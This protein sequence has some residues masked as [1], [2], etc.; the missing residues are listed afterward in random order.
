MHDFSFQLASNKLA[1]NAILETIR[2]AIWLKLDIKIENIN[3]QSTNAE[4]QNPWAV[5][6]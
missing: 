2:Y 6:I 1:L 3:Y 5:R 4:S